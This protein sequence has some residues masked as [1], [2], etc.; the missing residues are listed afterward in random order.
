MTQFEII[1]ALNV[2]RPNALWSIKG[3]TYNGLVWTDTVQTK[4]TEE[5]VNNQISVNKNQAPFVAC[6]D[7]SKKRIAATD[8]SVLPDVGISNVSEFE[9]YRATLREFIKTPVANPVYPTEPQPIWV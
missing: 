3:E 6:K 8:W 7:E 4:P 2:L 9:A 1:D 5:E